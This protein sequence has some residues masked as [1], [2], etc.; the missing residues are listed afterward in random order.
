M[1]NHYRADTLATS[2]TLVT[3]SPEQAA[4]IVLTCVIKI[5]HRVNSA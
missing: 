3:V 4:Q 5:R 2:D 1:T